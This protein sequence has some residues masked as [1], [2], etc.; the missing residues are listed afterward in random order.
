MRRVCD[1]AFAGAGLLILSPLLA[2]IAIAIKATSPGPVLF[3][4][5]RVGRNNQP[6]SMPKFRTMRVGAPVV[7]SHLLSDPE[8]VI[9]AVGRWLRR[10]SLD[11]LPQLYSVL[12]GDL[13]LIGPRPALYNQVDLI[14]L[15]T[16][17]RVYLLRPGV[18]GWAQV[19]GRDRLSVEQKASLDEEYMQ[20]R[21]VWL[22]L[23][24]LWRTIVTVLRRD[25]VAH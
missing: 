10:W 7:A 19:N 5:D 11:E 15:R 20:R 2:L 16:R 25:G 4:S 18:T 9:T 24:I 12:I 21:T 17:S 1:V 8:S 13:T 22:D 6:F 23:Q 3:W 14:D